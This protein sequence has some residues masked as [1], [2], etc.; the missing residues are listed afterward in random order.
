MNL[1]T[2]SLFPKSTRFFSTQ[3]LLT[4]VSDT[5]VPQYSDPDPE[6]VAKFNEFLSKSHRLLVLTGAGISTESGIPD[7]RS[8]DVGSFARSKHRPITIQEFLKSAE[9]RQRYW[10]RNYVGWPSFSSYLPNL[11]HKILADWEKT[12][13]LVQLITQMWIASI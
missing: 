12:G 4:A 1:N 2:L 8:K 9:A 11:N 3:S 7:Y 6:D 13:R 5:F 10:A